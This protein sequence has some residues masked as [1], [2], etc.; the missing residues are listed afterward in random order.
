M[1]VVVGGQQEQFL[2]IFRCNGFTHAT[3]CNVTIGCTVVGE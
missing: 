2:S 3:S 1:N